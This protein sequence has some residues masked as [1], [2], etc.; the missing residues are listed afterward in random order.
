MQF[1]R[2]VKFVMVD[3]KV[4]MIE[5]ELLFYHPTNT[6]IICNLDTVMV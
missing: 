2:K 4:N 5:Y 6:G 3:L 1:V